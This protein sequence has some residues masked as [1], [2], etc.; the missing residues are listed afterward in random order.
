VSLHSES[1]SGPTQVSRGI[2][3][4]GEDCVGKRRSESRAGDKNE[5]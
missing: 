5:G 2:E 1:G 3:E 4:V